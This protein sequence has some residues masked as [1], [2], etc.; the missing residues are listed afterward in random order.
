MGGKG[1][2]PSASIIVLGIVSPETG[3]VKEQS[4]FSSDQ[5]LLQFVSAIKPVLSHKRCHCLRRGEVVQHRRSDSGAV[6]HS[7][8]GVKRRRNTRW[9][10]HVPLCTV[11]QIASSMQA[12]RVSKA[13]LHSVRDDQ[14]CSCIRL[15][16]RR[17]G[18]VVWS[19]ISRSYHPAEMLDRGRKNVPC[20]AIPCHI[21]PYS[22]V[23][24][25]AG[26]SH[27]VLDCVTV[28]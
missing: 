12:C 14:S 18:V 24:R 1:S 25:Y 20:R 17:A 23:P 15:R 22:V 9:S 6:R 8:G 13:H 7:E 11:Q 10:R 21:M 26:L 28:I 3:K 5:L 4:L 27:L 2:A 16:R 19:T